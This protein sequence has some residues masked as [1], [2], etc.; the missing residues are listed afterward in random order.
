MSTHKWIDRICVAAVILALLLTAAFVNGEA[1]GI[2]VLPSALGYEERLFDTSRVHTIDIVMDD[3]DSFIETCENE[4]YA[5]CSVVID[6]ESYPNVGLR[7][8]GNTS[9]SSV[10]SMGSQRYSFKLEFDQYDSTKSY[11]GLD[12]LSLNNLIQDN[13]LMKDYLTYQLM[14]QFGAAA[15]LCSY[16]YITVNGQDWGLYLAV[17]GVEESFLER[18]YGSDYG[19]LYKPDSLSMGGGRGNGMD[20]DME[21]FSAENF[22]TENFDMGNLDMGNLDMGSFSP[23]DFA[24][25]GFTPPENGGMDWN[26]MMPGGS[27][28]SREEGGSRGD[29]ASR[30]AEGR[31][32]G[33]FS[34]GGMGDMFGGFG[35]GMGSSDV[36]LQYVD[37]DPD[38]YPNI[39]GSA[40]T[41][42]TTADEERLIRS[43][44]QL[45]QGEN[46]ESV[47]DVEA[48]MRY[49]VVHNFVCNDDSYTGTMIH[50]YYLYEED[51]QLSMLPWDYNLAYGGF[52]AGDASGTVNDDITFGNVSD[53]PM[54]SWIFADE[55]YT[56][57]YKEYYQEFVSRFVDGDGLALLVE[58]TARLIA[59]YVEKDPTKF[60]TYEEFEAGVSAL[61]TFCRLRGESVANQLAGDD[62]PVDASGLDLSDMGSMGMGGGFG[63]GDRGGFS[64]EDFGGMSGSSGETE[65]T[66]SGEVSAE[67]SAPGGM[68]A[69]G[70]FP[71]NMPTDG[72]F[73]GGMPADGSFPSNMPADGS[74]TGE[75]PTDGSFPSDM[76]TDGSFTGGMPADGSFP[77]NMPTDGSFTGGMPA[78]GSF[79]GNMPTGGSFFGSMTGDGT[80]ASGTTPSSGG[81]PGMSQGSSGSSD[82][83]Q[84]GRVPASAQSGG[85]LLALGVS[86]V[87]LA[88]G[89]VF[90]LCYK[91]RK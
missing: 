32:E 17:E 47:V 71:S 90:A 62:T 67:T 1:L 38:S 2:G 43:L 14:G 81:M 72:S 45:S 57:M 41:N 7:A 53:R 22:D 49:F 91:R 27:G 60:C 48:V 86:V 36:K 13:T 4:E 19:D 55:T 54:V 58:E 31:G 18:N 11:Y 6:G 70:S 28:G 8:K 34:F 15:P 78:D 51:G 87:I 88:A 74:F 37:D 30:P 46:I 79:P 29:G 9:L 26:Q 24:A 61:Q 50:N 69:D 68:P 59:P 39:F 56:Q 80:G 5:L 25:G 23:E 73:T 3:W 10:S 82:R 75:I 21:E 42:V 64:P 84:S 85:E 40:K 89:L 35:F 76:P 12:K 66:P 63:G 44:K 20:F 83:G 77:S 16:V 52:Q 33:G 65:K